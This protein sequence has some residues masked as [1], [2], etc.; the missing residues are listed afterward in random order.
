TCDEKTDSSAKRGG[1]LPILPMLGALGF[2]IGG[3]AGVAKAVN[4]SK[5][6]RRQLEEL[7]RH[8]RAMEQGR[9]LYLAPYKHGYGQK[10]KKKNVEETIRMPTGATTNVQLDLI[11]QRMRVLYF[12]GIFM[13]NALPTSGARRNESGIVNLNDATSPGVSRTGWR[14]RRGTTASCT[15]TVSAISDRPRNSCDTSAFL[16]R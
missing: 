4:D 9:G 12:R 10:R 6:A 11:A 15:L 1:V 7:Q 2:L 5:A 14:T 13:L 16:P 3:A 8:D